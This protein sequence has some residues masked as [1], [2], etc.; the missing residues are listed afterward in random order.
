VHRRR[1]PRLKQRGLFAA[2]IY[3]EDCVILISGASGNAGGAV[4]SSALAS[5]LPVRAMYRNRQNAATAPGG[6]T[7][8]IA[9]FGDRESL[10]G[11]LDGIERVYLVCGPIPQLVE[12]ESNMIDACRATGV[13][14]VVL[15]SALGAGRFPKSFPSWH[16]QVE[17]KLQ[18]SGLG[19]TILRPNGFM[20]NIAAYNGQSIRSENAFYAAMGD[21]RVSLID[22]RDVGAVAAMILGAPEGHNGK[23]YELNGPDAV[24]SAEI[25]GRLSHSIGRQ[26]A[27]IDIP[28]ETQRQAMLS[29]GMPAWQVAAVLELQEYYRSGACGRMDG[30]VAELLGR[31]ARTLDGYLEETKAVF[32]ADAR[33]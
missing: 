25:A 15:N 3:K 11:A 19:Y 31:P 13:R 30:V 7:V 9:E 8:A 12:L 16:T 28:E 6:G 24:T 27:F 14:H 23:I 2:G 20:Q 26:V 29:A 17:A 22:V 1:S 33:P 10:L 18:A 5:G 21:A 32:T 4:L